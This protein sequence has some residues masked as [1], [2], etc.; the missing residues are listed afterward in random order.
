MAYRQ[1]LAAFSLTG[2][3]CL[4]SFNSQLL[5]RLF[6][7]LAF[8]TCLSHSRAAPKYPKLEGECASESDTKYTTRAA[9]AKFESGEWKPE[10]GTTR[11]TPQDV[12]GSRFGPPLSLFC[13]WTDAGVLGGEIK[14]V[15]SVTSKEDAP[16]VRV[17]EGSLQWRPPLFLESKFAKLGNVAYPDEVAA[18]LDIMRDPKMIFDMGPDT[19]D[20]ETAHEIFVFN[21]AKGSNPHETPDVIKARKRAREKLSKIMD[22]ILETRLTPYVQQRFPGVCTGRAG[23][24]CTPCFSLVRKY[25]A[26]ERRMHGIHRDGQA[27]VTVVISLSDYGTEYTGGLYISDGESRLVVPLD[28]GDAVVH[29]FDLLHGVDVTGDGERWSWILWYKDSESC[30]QYGHEWSRGCAEGNNTWHGLEEGGPIKAI[31][32]GVGQAEKGNN[33]PLCQYLYAWR[34]HLDPAIPDHKK[35][36]LRKEYMMRAAEQGFPEAMFKTARNVMGDKDYTSALNWFTKACSAGDADACFQYGQIQLML[37]SARSKGEDAGTSR[38]DWAEQESAKAIVF[39]EA[40]AVAG[41]SPSRGA[42]YAMYNLGVAHLFG[43]GGLRRDP[44]RAAEWFENSGL[45]EGMMATAHH[46]SALGQAEEAEEWQKRAKSMGFGSGERKMHLV[47]VGYELHSPWPEVS[48][49]KI[50]APPEW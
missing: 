2:S 28:R 45:P 48:I 1:R 7:L 39:F 4:E 27:L 11:I 50:P 21:G 33:M 3:S 22:P 30:E 20:Q 49:G 38:P 19:V 8:T 42:A 9:M 34:V 46:R 29:Q 25:R 36:V 32:F 15:S 23:R 5:A 26:G 47:Q 40:A 16:A 6:L 37:A 13:N 35:G 10:V 24:G 18:I 12:P 31:G 44:D 43:M 14:P 41:S 17:F